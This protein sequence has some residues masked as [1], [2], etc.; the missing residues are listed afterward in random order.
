M[1]WLRQQEPV[2]C[3]YFAILWGKKRTGTLEILVKLSS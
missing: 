2:V 1:A 3:Q